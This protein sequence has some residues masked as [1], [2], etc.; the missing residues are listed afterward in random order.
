MRPWTLALVALTGCYDWT[1]GPNAGATDAKATKEAGADV[2]S[3]DS[4]HDVGVDAHVVDAQKTPDAPPHADAGDPC[5]SLLAALS[6]SRRASQMCTQGATPPD[7]Q[8]SVV[9][10]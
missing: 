9:D 7:C 10:P 3:H 1:V 2:E 6:A 4:G 8:L 5:P